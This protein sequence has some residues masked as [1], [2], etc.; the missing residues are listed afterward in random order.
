[1]VEHCL[2]YEHE[3]RFKVDS[4]VQLE[5]IEQAYENDAGFDLFVSRDVVI[6]AGHAEDVPTGVFIEPEEGLYTTIMGRS[7]TFRE[8][9]ILVSMNLIDSGYRGEVNAVAYNFTHGTVRIHAGE[10]ICQ[11]VFHRLIPVKC[12][13]V[14]RLNSSMRGEK[15]FGSSGL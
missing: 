7:S 13:K 9:G 11:L 14:L 6:K 3:V 12:K 15:G 1:M 8:R 5:Y 10:R 4:N 2:N